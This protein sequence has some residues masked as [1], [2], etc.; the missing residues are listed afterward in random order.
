MIGHIINLIIIFIIVGSLIKRFREVA[1]TG[2]EL[3]D[4]EKRRQLRESDVAREAMGPDVG[5]G[6]RRVEEIPIPRPEPAPSRQPEVRTLEDLIRS[7]TGEEQTTQQDSAVPLRP[8]PAVDVYAEEA[9][10]VDRAETPAEERIARTRVPVSYAVKKKPAPVRLHGLR[11]GFG[12][13]DLVRGIVMSE[14]LSP[15][16]ALRQDRN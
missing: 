2:R 3:T 14:I 1:K 13:D 10:M 11:L 5:T 16:V 9:A 7:L 4:D 6:G 12:G 15:P 8:E